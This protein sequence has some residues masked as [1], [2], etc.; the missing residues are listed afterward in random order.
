VENEKGRLDAK[1]FVPRRGV[2]DVVPRNT[3]I[4]RFNETR[5]VFKRELC[6]KREA[7]FL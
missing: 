7:L 4:Y 2:A 1:V 5:E 6:S 3:E